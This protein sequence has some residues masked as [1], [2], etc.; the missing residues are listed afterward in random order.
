[1]I[2]ASIKDIRNIVRILKRKG[3]KVYTRPYELN[4]VGVRSKDV[5][6][7]E[8]DDKLY[9]F[10][11]D[12]KGKWNLEAYDMTTDPSMQNLKIP[13]S[14]YAKKAGT[15]ILKGGQYV[16]SYEVGYH[17]GKKALRQIKPVTVYRNWDRKGYLFFDPSHTETGIFGI[18]IHGT[19]K[20]N[21][22]K[23]IGDWSEGCQVVPNMADFN[24]M[25]F[26]ADR[27]KS[28]YGNQLTYTLIDE[29]MRDQ[30]M[31]RNLIISG[32]LVGAGILTY[33]AF[34][35][36]IKTLWTKN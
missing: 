28:M 21:I 20:D 13:K 30:Q 22:P 25:L 15:A 4:I 8:F 27:H 16:D 24:G 34:G 10:W 14:D 26:L 18:N 2:Q 12:D 7:L 23:N 31:R 33:V 29:Y 35:K 36:K 32:I 3:Y 17:K 5:R 6:P 9:V 19:S 1:M 11:K